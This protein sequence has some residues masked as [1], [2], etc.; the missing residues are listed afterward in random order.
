MSLP[1][2][3]VTVTEDTSNYYTA[4]IPFIP[5]VLMK[6]MSGN[7][8]TREI[9]RSEQ[10]FIAKFGK[11]TLNTPSAYAIQLYLRTY[12]FIY[13]T[14]LA[15]PNAEFGKSTIQ[16]TIEAQPVDLIELST[17][18]KTNL[19]NGTEFSLVYDSAN[20]KLY[21]TTVIDSQTISSIKETID[22]SSATASEL[23]L[24][25]NKIC[26][27]INSM[28][29][30][31]TATNKFVNKIS[32]D[33]V[34]SF[35]SLLGTIA[36]G[37]SG[38]ENITDTIVMSAMELYNEDGLDIDTM[39]VPEFNS[40]NVINRGVELAEQNN[41][42]FL[43]T[44]AGSSYTD[45]I[46]N[47]SQLPQSNA[48]ALYYPNVYYSNFANPIPASIAVLHAY[49]RNDN[50]NKWLSPAGT[51]RGVLTL[52]TSLTEQLTDDNMDA[53][54]NATIS[55]NPIKYI[56]GYGYCVWGQKTTDVNA[57]YLDRINI[58]RLTKYTYKEVYDIT[59]SFLFEPISDTTYSAWRLRVG[60]LLE[61]LK[62]NGAISDYR[63]KMDDENNTDATKA[64]NKLIGFISIKPIEV[65]EFIDIELVLT[66]QV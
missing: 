25:L 47:A 66:S 3:K 39:A 63:Y 4:Q 13:V 64:Q 42:M 27:S 43:A 56:S 2:V 46:T 40:T 41:F 14:R 6:T 37:D 7:V 9:V 1:R 61:D 17:V 54:Y 45:I 35:V 18:Y 11:G 19:Y 31:I 57:A 32:T 33:D 8:G 44:P 36:E 23:E 59:S 50:I 60:T 53:L 20:T 21:M 34:P 15:G 29:L 28:S 16:A 52:T 26:N 30:G 5:A 58:S 10:E 65:A 12:S 62:T 51:S 55:V 48:L 49:A 24:A 38:L 22:L